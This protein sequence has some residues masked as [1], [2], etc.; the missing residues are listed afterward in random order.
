MWLAI[1]FPDV[2]HVLECSCLLH[3]G[4]CKLWYTLTLISLCDSKLCSAIVHNCTHFVSCTALWS[5]DSHDCWLLVRYNCCTVWWQK[6]SDEI[7]CMGIVGGSQCCSVIVKF[8]LS[9][10]TGY[11][12]V[13]I[14]GCDENNHIC[15]CVW[16]CCES[17]GSCKLPYWQPNGNNTVEL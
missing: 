15:S 13:I 4:Q 17:C 16:F 12:V 10:C 2:Q 5:D 9:L 11:W 7:N 8:T 1:C 6:T 3:P 14:Y